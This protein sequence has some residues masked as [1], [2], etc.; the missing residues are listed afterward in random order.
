M[1]NGFILCKNFLDSETL[2]ETE[3]ILRNFHHAWLLQ[4]QDLFH[5]GAI[6]SAYL[7]K[8][9]LLAPEDR[10]KIFKLVG[11]QKVTALAQKFLKQKFC[12][13]NT[14]IFFNPYNSQQ[15]NYWHRD[16]QYTGLS[17]SDQRKTIEEKKTQVVHLRLALAEEHGLEF[18]PGSQSRWDTPEE[19]AVRL[20]EAGKC[21]SD[22]ISSGE[23]V[24]LRRGDLLLFDANIIHRG[25]YGVDRFAFDILFCV[26]LPEVVKFIDI[27]TY[28]SEAELN[29]IEVP[30]VFI[31]SC[32]NL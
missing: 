18:V 25:L 10:L 19:L 16:I 28:P 26:Q 32:K 13:L 30:E 22:E 8:G 15:K 9:P 17:L 2:D 29:R 6:N 11:S 1:E 31:L 7:T 12:F 23:T 5:K 24:S 3:R 14:Q 21:S 20:Q 4:N 27:D